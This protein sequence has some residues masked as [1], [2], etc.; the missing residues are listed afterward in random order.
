MKK[1]EIERRIVELKS[2]YVRLQSDLEKLTYVG[3]NGD[4]TEKVL[5]AIEEELKELRILL[6]SKSME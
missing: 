6:N 3:R 5:E 4:Q 1:D 2:D